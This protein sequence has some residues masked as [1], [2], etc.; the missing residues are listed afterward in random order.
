MH[1]SGDT[2]RL[3]D[4]LIARYIDDDYQILCNFGVLAT[5]FD[6]PKVDVV[7]IGRPTTSAVLAAR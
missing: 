5:G 3:R 4:T 7:C 6:A 2:P 1:V